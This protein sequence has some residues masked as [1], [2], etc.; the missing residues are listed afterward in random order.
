MCSLNLFY[1]CSNCL[2][3]FLNYILKKKIYSNFLRYLFIADWSDRK[4][5]IS[6]SYLDGSHYEVLFDS[7]I[8]KWPNGVTIDYSDDRIF[9]T[10]AH[11]DYI[12]SSDFDG[13][14]MKYIIRGKRLI[15]HPFAVVV[16][17]VLHDCIKIS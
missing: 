2:Y 7:S 14:N 16:Y 11:E 3:Y 6:R 1:L 4:P 13:K 5:S 15:P 17:K 8:V 12:A 10:D 9:W